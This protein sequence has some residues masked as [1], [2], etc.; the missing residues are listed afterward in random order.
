VEHQPHSVVHP[1]VIAERL[2]P[3][4]MGNHPNPSGDTALDGP[5]QGPKNQVRHRLWD[6]GV[7][8]EAGGEAERSNDCEVGKEVGEGRH[9]GALEAVGGDG[10]LEVADGE[11]GLVLQGIEPGGVGKR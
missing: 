5:V 6:G 8:E 1:A 11:G 4:L 2:V 7:L 10:A 3:A 9:Q